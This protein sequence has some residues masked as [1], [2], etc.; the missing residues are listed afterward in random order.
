[1]RMLC[2]YTFNRISL[3]QKAEEIKDTCFQI[4]QVSVLIFKAKKTT[5]NL[6]F[7]VTYFVDAHPERQRI[8]CAVLFYIV[9]FFSLP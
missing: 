2:F 5:E 4:S 1:M 3:L 7:F 9:E 6:R 8:S